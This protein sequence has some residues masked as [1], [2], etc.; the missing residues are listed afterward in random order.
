LWSLALLT[1]V[2]A[3]FI[4]HLISRPVGVLKKYA[5]RISQGDFNTPVDL[6]SQ[7]EFGQLARIFNQMTD[8]RTASGTGRT[9]DHR[10][11]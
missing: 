1:P 2:I 8:D 5:Q 9:H 7:D 3:Y 10:S 4:Y 6:R 11:A